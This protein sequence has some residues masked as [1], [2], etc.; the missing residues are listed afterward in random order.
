MCFCFLVLCQRVMIEYFS[1]IPRWRVLARFLE[2]PDTR[3]N[4]Q[5]NYNKGDISYNTAVR[6]MQ[7]LVSIGMVDFYRGEQDDNVFKLNKD[8][9]I[10]PPLRTAY[11]RIK[12]LSCGIGNEIGKDVDDLAS[13]SLIGAFVNGRFDVDSPVE[14]L[15]ITESN[16]EIPGR[17]IGR[18]EE[19]LGRRIVFQRYQLDE[20]LEL[21]DNN[22]QVYQKAKDEHIHILGEHMEDP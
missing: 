10:V 20:W 4:I 17:A 19:R 14:L 8:H 5:K 16:S 6:A 3:L 22:N 21:R 11:G 1:K 9:P 15:A 2:D 7:P 18:L 13:L 12:I